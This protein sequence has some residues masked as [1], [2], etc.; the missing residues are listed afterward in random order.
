MTRVREPSD[1]FRRQETFQIIRTSCSQSRNTFKKKVLLVLSSK[2][3]LCACADRRPLMH[4]WAGLMLLSKETRCDCTEQSLRQSSTTALPPFLL[5]AQE[6]QTLDMASTFNALDLMQSRTLEA[7]SI[8]GGIGPNANNV[9]A[10]CLS[11]DPEVACQLAI[12][13]SPSCGEVTYYVLTPLVLRD[14]LDKCIR[15]TVR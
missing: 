10:Q 3:G 5:I 7:L 1:S 14:N 9:L 12:S 13:S 15:H 6:V 4:G 11:F 2:E 8:V